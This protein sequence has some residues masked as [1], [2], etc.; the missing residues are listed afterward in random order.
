MST[1]PL[2]PII[3]AEEIDLNNLLNHLE[4]DINDWQILSQQLSKKPPRAAWTPEQKALARAK[5]IAKRAAWTPEQQQK[6]RDRDNKRYH[7]LTDE[8]KNKKTKKQKDKYDALPD[9]EKA[10]LITKRKE[11]YDALPDEEKR[12]KIEKNNQ[13]KSLK[14]IA[15]KNIATD[16]RSDFHN[17]QSFSNNPSISLIDENLVSEV[18]KKI[19]KKK[20]IA[21][22][23]R[24]RYNNM[25]KEQKDHKKLIR[26]KLEET[27]KKTKNDCLGGGSKKRIRR[28]KKKHIK[29]IRRSKKENNNNIYVSETNLSK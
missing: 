25:T 15:A 28:S 8:E 22:K 6:E 20:Q 29:R 3:L 24:G 27:K 10:S 12:K 23:E 16:T 13:K 2:S 21:L 7:A 5:Q 9:E 14:Q 11:R 1:Q 17:L 26:K 4:P 19:E 18:D